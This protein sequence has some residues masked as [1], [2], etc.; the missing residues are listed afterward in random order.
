MRFPSQF[1]TVTDI[2]TRHRT[3]RFLASL[4]SFLR[5]LFLRIRSVHHS[6]M[7]FH[8]GKN[9]FHH[10]RIRFRVCAT[11]KAF[12]LSTSSDH[13]GH[14]GDDHGHRRGVSCGH[15]AAAVAQSRP[16][17]HITHRGLCKKKQRLSWFFIFCKIHPSINGLQLQK[18]RRGAL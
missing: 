6:G 11:L 10:S 13:G 1:L 2:A 8:F 4:S 14:D 3:G 5:V 7:F 12:V 16:P 15:R 18:K 9:N 17:L